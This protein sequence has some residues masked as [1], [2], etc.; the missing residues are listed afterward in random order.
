M[1]T[2]GD[3]KTRLDGREALAGALAGIEPGDS[4]TLAYARDGAEATVTL[5][6]TAR[7]GEVPAESPPPPASLADPLAGPVDAVEVARLESVEVADPPLAVIPRCAGP[8]GVVVWC[9]PPR[10]TVAEAE[11]AAWKAA[12][13]RHG[14]AVILP[15]SGE[16]DAWSRGDIE[17]VTRSLA[18]LHARKPLDP[19]RI[20]V[21]G[22]GAGAAFAWLVAERLGSGVGGVSLVDAALPRRASVT[23]AAPGAARWILLGPGRDDATRQRVEADRARLTQAGHAAGL[24]PADP[25]SDEA[26]APPAELLCRWAALLGLL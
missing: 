24:L 18:S 5:V 17:T 3:T 23:P 19:A 2:V 13:A 16:A 9:G 1:I 11:A 7:G 22:R 6:T 21:A 26:A 4:V 25:A 14:V 8:I 10:G 20:A 15:G 12:A